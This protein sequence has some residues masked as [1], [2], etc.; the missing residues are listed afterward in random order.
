M[1]ALKYAYPNGL[2][3][4]IRI[5]FKRTGETLAL[6]VEDDGVGYD[7]K[8]ASGLGGRIVRAMATKLGG[9]VTQQARAPGMR[10][11]V[12]FAEGARSPED[13]SGS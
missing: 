6:A 4:P 12:A 1:N 7:V 10:V 5:A 3:G 8:S 2:N 13:A 9:N 11:E